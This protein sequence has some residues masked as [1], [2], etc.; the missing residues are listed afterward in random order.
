M[1]QTRKRTKRSF[2]RKS[3][4]GLNKVEKKQTKQIVESAIK[5]ENVLK[6]FNSN[7][8]PIAVAPA[9]STVSNIKEV[10]CI[11]F[12]STTEFDSNQ[13][14]I[15]YGQK[16]YVPLMLARPFKENA[17]DEVLRNLALNSQYCLPKMAKAQFSIERVAYQIADMFGGTA[18]TPDPNL[19]R[20]Y[21]S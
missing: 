9:V 16:E 11:A 17:T 13:T 14:A 20:T 19:A 7:S 8:V 4:A 3:K 15:L 10:S 1:P 6:Y 18:P 2:T 12:S 5:K 21:R